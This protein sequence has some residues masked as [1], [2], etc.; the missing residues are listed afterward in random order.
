MPRR[1]AQESGLA[2]RISGIGRLIG[3]I[4]GGVT[5]GGVRGL[6]LAALGA[7]V[8]LLPRTGRAPSCLDIRSLTVAVQT[9]PGILVALRRGKRTTVAGNVSAAGETHAGEAADVFHCCL[10]DVDLGVGVFDPADG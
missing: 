2:V 8:L 4:D 10:D 5:H 7:C 3:D 9:L 6:A 1:Y